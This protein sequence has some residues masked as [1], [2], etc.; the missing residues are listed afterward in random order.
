M[1]NH[2]K[3]LAAY[4]TT[5]WTVYGPKGPAEVRPGQPAPGW[6][7]RSGVV[8]GWNPG[9]E[10]RQ[11]AINRKANQRLR[12]LL[13]G[14]GATLF[15][16]TARGTG[17]GARPWTEPGFAVLGLARERLVEIAH[18]FGQNA[19][20]WIGDAGVAELVAARP[21]FAGRSPGET[22]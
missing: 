12:R 6:L 2:Q 9:S 21:G 13:A 4:R 18:D 19:I 7:L 17:A 3:L 1:P 15:A 11:G 5:R 22:L 14:E 16:T 20:I 8:T 10:L